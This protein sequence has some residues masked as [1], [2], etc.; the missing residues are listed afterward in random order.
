MNE[1]L[2]SSNNYFVSASDVLINAAIKRVVEH[3]GG[4]VVCCQEGETAQERKERMKKIILSAY[5]SRE[6]YEKHCEEVNKKGM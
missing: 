1:I 4:L 6:R 3:N 5:G 2:E